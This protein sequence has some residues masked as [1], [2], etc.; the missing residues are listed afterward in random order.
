MAVHQHKGM[1]GRGQTWYGTGNGQ[2]P[3]A[4]TDYTVSS[5]AA[6]GRT[7]VFKDRDPT[8]RATGGEAPRRSD[9][10]VVCRLVRNV[11]G[12]ALLPKRFVKYQT[13]YFRK[14]IDGYHIVDY[15]VGEMP[16]GVVDEFLTSS[17]AANHDLFWIVENGPTL[18][19]TG[20][21][22]DGTNVFSEYTRLVALTAAA[23]THSTTAGRPQPYEE[24]SSVTVAQRQLL[25]I[26]GVA[27]SAKTT[28]NTNVDMLADIQIIK[29]A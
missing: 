20:P 24:T 2:M 3:S 26:L 1:P 15:N 14:R 10:D 29:A 4:S 23:S 25:N 13:A 5:T 19:T 28:A 9:R 21:G 11:S 27:L 17:G 22:A 12:I 8:A 6:E 16:A 18:V 7:M